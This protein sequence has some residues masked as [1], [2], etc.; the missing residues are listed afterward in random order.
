MTEIN[1]DNNV[2]NI[3]LY[4]KVWNM[5][6][7]EKD[8]NKNDL[9][10]IYISPK[11]FKSVPLS[12]I[13]GYFIVLNDKFIDSKGFTEYFSRFIPQYQIKRKEMLNLE[14]KVDGKFIPFENKKDFWNFVKEKV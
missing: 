5:I 14:K 6:D 11:I 13:E 3:Y 7:K 9:I 10:S 4:G 8:Q 12:S 2:K 1:I